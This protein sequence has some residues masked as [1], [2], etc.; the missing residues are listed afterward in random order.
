M[1]EEARDDYRREMGEGTRNQRRTA[2]RTGG[3]HRVSRLRRRK[4]HHRAGRQLQR[5]A[6]VGW[7]SAARAFRLLAETYSARNP[8]FSAPR[9]SKKM[10][11][12]ARF[13][14]ST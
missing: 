8:T 10:L 11:G 5:R 14:S 2:R 4:L 3:D 12:Y 7:V 9:D 1:A 13:A 6:I